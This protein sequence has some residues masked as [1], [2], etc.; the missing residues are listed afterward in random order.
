MKRIDFIKSLG[1]LPAA[2]ML[3]AV[4]MGER[5]V[6]KEWDWPILD[7]IN[8][9]K[10]GTIF[11]T[12]NAKCPYC[13]GAVHFADLKVL[14]SPGDDCN[15]LSSVIYCKESGCNRAFGFGAR[16]RKPGERVRR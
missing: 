2:F 12:D 4:L 8:E 9:M 6:E 7:S 14:R 15:T 1:V 13:G 16:G 10:V 3:P 5:T 11:S